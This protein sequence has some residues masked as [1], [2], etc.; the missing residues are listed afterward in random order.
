M[1][2]QDAGLKMPRVVS[3]VEED[4]LNPDRRPFKCPVCDG[5]G[6]VSRPP[7][8]AGDVQ[9]WSAADADPYECGSCAGSGIVWGP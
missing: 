6:K 5:T 2:D 7:W 1:P 9:G 8:M 4:G 3:T